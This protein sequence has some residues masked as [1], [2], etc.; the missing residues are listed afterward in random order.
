MDT[1]AELS[2]A[3]HAAEPVCLMLIAI[4]DKAVSLDAV[5]QVGW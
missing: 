1:A 4:N 5:W 3:Q 2:M